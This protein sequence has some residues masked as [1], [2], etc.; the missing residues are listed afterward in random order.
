MVEGAGGQP[1]L[2]PPAGDI[3]ETWALEGGAG[4]ERPRRFSGLLAAL[5]GLVLIGGG[6]LDASRYGQRPDPRNAGTNRCRDELELTLVREALD[7]DLPVLAVCRGM[8]VLNVALGGSL[9]QQLPAPAGPTHQP[10]P[11]EFGPVEVIT[12]PASTVGRLLGARVE[13]QCSHHQV[14]ATVAPGLVVTGRSVDGVIE[15]VELPG[16]RFVIGVQWHPEEAGDLRLFEALVGAAR[17]FADRPAVED[18]VGR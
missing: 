10:R 6:D 1:V 18:G 14:L 2:V 3:G 13:V 17:A 4:S 9:I 8:Q 15:A 11:G 7:L 5:G 12:E 16:R